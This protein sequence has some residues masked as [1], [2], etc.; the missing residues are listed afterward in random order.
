MAR[1]SPTRSLRCRAGMSSIG[2]STT[3]CGRGRGGAPTRRCPPAARR[4]R[5][6]P[7]CRPRGRRHIE[8]DRT[9]LVAAGG[10]RRWESG[11]ASVHRRREVGVRDMG[12]SGSPRSI[13]RRRDGPCQEL[14]PRNSPR[15]RWCRDGPLVHVSQRPAHR[16]TIPNRRTPRVGNFSDQK[17]GNSVIAVRAS[18]HSDQRKPVHGPPQGPAPCFAPPMSM[19]SGFCP[20][21]DSGTAHWWPTELPVRGQQNCPGFSWSVA[22]PPFRRW[23]G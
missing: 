6:A 23:L 4:R 3:R 15:C 20:V 18:L 5:M 11:S 21:A 8:S 2:A 12:R 13:V 22:S 19:A 10:P 7:A 17:W 9:A 1:F 16:S 14:S